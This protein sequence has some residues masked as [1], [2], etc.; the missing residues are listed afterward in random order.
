MSETHVLRL[1]RAEAKRKASRRDVDITQLKD[2][3]DKML[4]QRDVA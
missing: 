3:F 4:Q 2:Q 1:K